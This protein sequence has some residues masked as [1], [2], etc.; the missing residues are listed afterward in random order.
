M[1]LGI[2][3]AL[4]GGSQQR[5]RNSLAADIGQHHRQTFVGIDRVEKVASD[6]LTGKIPALQA[7]ERNF[8]NGHRHEPLLNGRGDGKFLLVAARRFFGLHQAGVFDQGSSL[9]RDGPQNIVAYARDISRGEARIHIKRSHHLGGAFA[10]HRRLRVPR[11]LHLRLAQGNADHGA[12]IV[13]HNAVPAR[14]VER[15]AG[16]CNH[17]LGVGLHRLIEDG[18]RNRGVVQQRFALGVAPGGQTQVCPLRRA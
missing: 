16:V 1:K 9:G 18:V 12:Q 6:F 3:H 14:Q 10:W 2:D 11:G 15:L 5:R 17:E 4:K 7:R 8:G 13:S